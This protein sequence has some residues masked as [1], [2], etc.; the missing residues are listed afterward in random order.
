MDNITVGNEG[1]SRLLN[2]LQTRKAVK[3]SVCDATTTMG[4]R[5]MLYFRPV[6]KLPK[7][8]D[9]TVIAV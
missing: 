5:G 7:C 8:A 4:I 3:L 9:F 1:I 2:Y 6:S